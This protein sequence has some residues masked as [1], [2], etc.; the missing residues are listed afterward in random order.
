M[1]EAI[2]TFSPNSY[3]A[4][5]LKHT[6]RMSVHGGL[7]CGAGAAFLIAFISIY[8]HK[9]NNKWSHFTSPH[10]IMGLTTLILVAGTACGGILA[11]Y[12]FIISRLIRPVYMKIIHSSFGM[13]TYLMAMITVCLGLDS[14]WFRKHINEAL[15]AVLISFV[16]VSAV[17]VVI[18]PI[19]KMV[20]RLKD[21]M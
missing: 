1:T 20:K 7:Q 21:R 19:I 5:N 4:R 17:L 12:S 10:G 16:A 15:V 14:A 6:E 3:L 13:I 2:I 8:N 18:Q 9:L 11:R